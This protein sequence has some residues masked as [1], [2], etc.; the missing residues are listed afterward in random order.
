MENFINAER[1]WWKKWETSTWMDHIS[2]EVKLFHADKY[3][4]FFQQPMGPLTPR[5]WTRLI[6]SRG[7]PRRSECRQ[8]TSSR[9][10]YQH[11]CTRWFYKFFLVDENKRVMGGNFRLDRQ[12]VNQKRPS[13]V[14][15]TDNTDVVFR[16]FLVRFHGQP[17][18]VETCNSN[19]RQPRR[20]MPSSSH[21]TKNL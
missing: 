9:N 5:S 14:A 20:Q 18:A 1:V 3:W 10:N 2:S 12:G 7:I 15:R 11:S 4:K 8:G 13:S 19:K 21:T 16:V 17:A 6:F